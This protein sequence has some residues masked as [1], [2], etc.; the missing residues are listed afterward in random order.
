MSH[1]IYGLIALAAVRAGAGDDVVGIVFIVCG[2]QEVGLAGVVGGLAPAPEDEAIKAV[3]VLGLVGSAA[4]KDGSRIACHGR[5]RFFQ[6][7]SVPLPRT[8][9]RARQPRTC[10]VRQCVRLPRLH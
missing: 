9:A 3:S 10:T 1:L 2:R 4:G 7:L 5:N 6:R 8:G